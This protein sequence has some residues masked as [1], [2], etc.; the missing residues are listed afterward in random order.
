MADS[1]NPIRLVH[2]AIWDAL[3]TKSEFTDLFPNGTR[4]QM[5]YD[6]TLTYPIDP[7]PEDEFVYPAWYPICRVHLVG[8]SDPRKDISSHNSQL[9]MRWRIDVATGQQ[10]QRRLADALWAIYLSYSKLI[11][12]SVDVVEWNSK[13]YNLY[14]LDEAIEITDQSKKENR[15]TIQWV[16]ACQLVTAMIFDTA[17][18]VAE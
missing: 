1:N 10:T 4:H 2:D 6:S 3:E 13:K 17:D 18:L 5:R 9:N 7:W 12:Q 11:D 15:G 8:R 16:A 14:T